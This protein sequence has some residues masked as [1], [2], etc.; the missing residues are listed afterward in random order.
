[1]PY[2]NPDLVRLMNRKQLYRPNVSSNGACIDYFFISNMRFSC[3]KSHLR[4]GRESMR[5]LMVLGMGD[6]LTQDSGLGIYAVRD[7]CQEGWPKEVMFLDKRHL[8]VNDVMHLLQEQEFLLILDVLK[9]GSGPGT[10]Y[11]LSIQDLINKDYFHNDGKLWNSLFLSEIMGQKIKVVFLGLEPAKTNWELNLSSH[12][13]S[14]YQQYLE[15]V[16]NELR[17]ML[18]WDL[19]EQKTLQQAGIA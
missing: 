19:E 10:M 2:T 16:R 12:L 9:A 18:G 8:E 14:V 4:G 5:G 3:Q 11:R 6:V 15:S 7:L 17:Y 1:M 13:Q